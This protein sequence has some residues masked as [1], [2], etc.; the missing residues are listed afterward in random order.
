MLDAGEDAAPVTT[1]DRFVN[2]PSDLDINA[3]ATQNPIVDPSQQIQQAAL[4]PRR[5]LTV[6]WPTVSPG[7]GLVLRHGPLFN[8]SWTGLTGFFSRTRRVCG[9]ENSNFC[10]S[11]HNFGS[12]VRRRV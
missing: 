11:S 4:L 8:G 5:R 1:V 6:I 12:D 3:I 7:F 10:I 9:T 2:H